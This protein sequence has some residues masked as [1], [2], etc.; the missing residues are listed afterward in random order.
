MLLNSLQILL[1]YSDKD[2]NFQ[3]NQVIKKELLKG[4]AKLKC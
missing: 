3:Y 2:T 4:S 1:L